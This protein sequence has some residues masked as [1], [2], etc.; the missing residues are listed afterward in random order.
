MGGKVHVILEMLK[1][2]TYQ[3]G[4]DLIL[5]SQLVLQIL[6]VTLQ[7]MVSSD[8]IFTPNFVIFYYPTSPTFLITPFPI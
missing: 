6:I 5:L 4:N 1:V 7:G 2:V 3:V 8:A